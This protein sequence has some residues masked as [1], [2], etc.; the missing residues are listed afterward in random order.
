MPAYVVVNIEV[1]DPVPYETY[2]Q[3]AA[4]TVLK[5]G[6]RYIARGGEVQVLEGD[7]SPKRLVILEFPN[8]E[9]AREW[10]NS[11]DYA[12]PKSLR[13]SCAKSQLV[14]LDALPGPGSNKEAADVGQPH[15]RF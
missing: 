12:G 7:W 4:A 3:N 13:Q 15:A 8:A 9:R 2:K 6:G 10:W 11:S 1:E 5:H 14:L